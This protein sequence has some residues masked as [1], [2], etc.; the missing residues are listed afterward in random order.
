MTVYA[1]VAISQNG[2]IGMENKLP[3]RLPIDLKWFKMN[4]SASV[5][6]MGRRTWDSLPI[7]PLPNRLN[8]ILSRN[9]RKSSK[10]IIWSSSVKNALHCASKH[11]SNTFIIGGAQIYD[12][13]SEYV[14]VWLITRVHIPIHS[15]SVTMYAFPDSLK[16]IWRSKDIEHK[17]TTFHFEMLKKIK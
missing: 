6:I 14:D 9:P 8:I 17:G 13:F 4:T 3:W 11:S 5:V 10:N 1:I 16:N 12:A 15:P 7:Q 2:V